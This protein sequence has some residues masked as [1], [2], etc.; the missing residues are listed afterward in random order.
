MSIG[1][2]R[3]VLINSGN[4]DYADL[5]LS[6]SG[7]LVGRNN[8]G[9]T[10]LIAT[11][12][13]LYGA[14]E[15]E[16]Q[17][18]E[19][20]DKSRAF[21]FASAKSF[22]IFVCE[23]PQGLKTTV[24]RGLGP[25]HEHKYER[26]VYD[27][28]YRTEDYFD[29]DNA[30]REPEAI[31]RLLSDREFRVVKPEEYRQVLLGTAS[32]G[33]PNLG[34]VPV[35]NTEHYRRFYLVFRSLINLGHISNN[36]F[37]D[38][39]IDSVR[40]EGIT[41][42]IA[43]LEKWGRTYQK[44][45][46]ETRGVRV[47]ERS[48]QVVEEVLAK[49]RERAELR[50]QI[51]VLFNE[52]DQHYRERLRAIQDQIEAHSRRRA[53]LDEQHQQLR[54]RWEE[55]NAALQA[56]VREAGGIE[57]MIRALQQ[58]RAEFADFD[59][60]FTRQ[61]LAVAQQEAAALEKAVSGAA[62]ESAAAIEARL[63]QNRR[64]L[65]VQERL[66]SEQADLLV[67]RLRAW[68]GDEELERLFRLGNPAL[69]TEKIGEALVI[70]DE[71]A[72][73][74][75]LQALLDAFDGEVFASPGV[76]IDVSTLQGPTLARILD[77]EQVR[78]RI[79]ALKRQLRADE[80]ILQVAQD[81]EAHRAQLGERKAEIEA[82]QA[83]L[84]DYD[85]L[86]KELAGLPELERQ[87][88][89]LEERQLRQQQLL[90]ELDAQ[91]RANRQADADEGKA[92]EAAIVAGK[93]LE[94]RK[95]LLDNWRRSN[96]DV[97]SWPWAEPA[98]SVESFDECETQLKEYT[99]RHDRLSEQI[100]SQL[101]GLAGIEFSSVFMGDAGEETQLARLQEE[102]DALDEKRK[103]LQEHWRHLA[104][105][106]ADDAAK[107]LRSMEIVE[108]QVRTLNG[109]IAELSIS[110]LRSLALRIEHVDERVKVLRRLV[111]QVGDD[112]MGLSFGGSETPEQTLDRIVRELQQR[113]VF[114]LAE[115]FN[116]TFEVE[117]ASGKTKIY[118]D[119][120]KVESNGT[121]ISTK[122]VVFV[123]LL[124][125]ILKSR[126]TVRLPFYLDEVAALDPVNARTIVAL[127]EQLDFVPV[128]ASP[129][130]MDVASVIYYLEPNARNRIY[131]GPKQR[132]ELERVRRELATE[133][134]EAELTA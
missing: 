113:P 84:L 78:E 54:Q 114:E 88:S 65:Q 17:F 69:L 103:T 124:R 19:P 34:L 102:R 26:W 73:R 3:L 68:F 15:R 96:P 93:Q 60:D 64:E 129:S 2:K 59:P 76:R 16:W 127:A 112:Q 52:A 45:Q 98:F 128:L 25:L 117:L 101:S 44:L 13:F 29:D 28:D 22:V 90:D 94:Q 70:R 79:S 75:E 133:P 21:Y 83:R 33:L 92:L 63:T 14:T 99:G 27:G 74:S 132:Y 86:Q 46:A 6:R 8:L 67:T 134:A 81:L 12:Q 57:A 123:L 31:K 43:F 71:Q 100:R 115:L 120:A 95:L 30:I 55:Q 62:V 40:G 5:D 126:H 107:L 20:N 105:G 66:L 109:R 61:A 122:V 48:L 87:A 7:H 131:L 50:G 24:I 37:K 97:D 108:R 47:F 82:M 10:S 39:L 58:R 36:D 49:A 106:L 38:V 53:E 56:T 104:S 18:S 80:D 111:D 1:P 77:P 42:R 121:T 72:L 23:T 118:K 32:G 116:V 11:L 85:R 35:R 51:P 89:A 4:Y 119:L 9:K 125:D 41:D 110:N 130:A 91:Q